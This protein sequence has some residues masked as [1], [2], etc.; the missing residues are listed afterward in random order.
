MKCG[1]IYSNCT[2]NI[3]RNLLLKFRDFQIA[4]KGFRTVQYA[5]YFVL[6][7]KGGSVVQGIINTITEI[8]RCFVIEMN[9]KIVM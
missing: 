1:P 5:D 4:G 7:V 6:L 9:I 3:L 8:G 2:K